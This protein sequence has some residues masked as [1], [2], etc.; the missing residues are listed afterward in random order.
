MAKYEARSEQPVVVE[1]AYAIPEGW[2]IPN[3]NH[4]CCAIYLVEPPGW[5]VRLTEVQPPPGCLD[6][7]P[8]LS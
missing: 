6:V 7:L 5:E 8:G 2:V 1:N 3:G 4:R